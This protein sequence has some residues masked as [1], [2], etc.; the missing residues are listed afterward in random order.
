MVSQTRRLDLHATATG[1]P[2]GSGHLALKRR[3]NRACRMKEGCRW[4]GA[5]MLVGRGYRL[6]I[7]I[8]WDIGYGRVKRMYRFWSGG[9]KEVGR[10]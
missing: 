2:C 4:A 5:S 9:L 6:G 8:R 7:Y 3:T 10:R 1:R